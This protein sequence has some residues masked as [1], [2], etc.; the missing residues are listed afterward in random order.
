LKSN[1]SL[2]TKQ[3]RRF[4]KYLIKHVFDEFIPMQMA[5]ILNVSN[6]TIIYWSQQLNTYDLLEQLADE[7]AERVRRNKVIWF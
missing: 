6:K 2:L 3:A 4:Y 5:E 7:G 1:L